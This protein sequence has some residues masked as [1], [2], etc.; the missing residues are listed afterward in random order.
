MGHHPLGSAADC[1]LATYSHL[2]GAVGACGTS[3]MRDQ[4]ARNHDM[5]NRSASSHHATVAPLRRMVRENDSILRTVQRTRRLRRAVRAIRPIAH[6]AQR[7][8]SGA[9][10]GRDAQYAKSRDF[11][12]LYDGSVV[13]YEK[14]CESRIP[15][16]GD[17]VRCAKSRPN[18]IPYNEISLIKRFR[19]G[20]TRHARITVCK[21]N[22]ISHTVQ[23]ARCTV[24]E[25][26]PIAHTVQRDTTGTQRIRRTVREIT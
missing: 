17:T 20:V 16:Y 14:S 10:S 9:R 7:A 2:S 8:G 6:T 4:P 25:I 5:R 19:R 12:I 1:S 23:R 3:R 13:Q 22:P 26:R 15:G 18:H 21:N 11:R 24:R